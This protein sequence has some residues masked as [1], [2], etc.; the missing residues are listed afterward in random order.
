MKVN[1]D[2]QIDEIFLNQ[3]KQINGDRE[4]DEKVSQEECSH[5][6]AR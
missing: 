2:R 6:N 5:K 1:R 3:L 4:I